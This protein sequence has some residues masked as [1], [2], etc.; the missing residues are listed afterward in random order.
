MK[1]AAVFGLS[2]MV[3]A[4]EAQVLALERDFMGRAVRAL[5]QAA[6]DAGAGL[7]PEALIVEQKQAELS[8]VLRVNHPAA[9][10]REL[11]NSLQPARP[12]L[13]PAVEGALEY[14]WR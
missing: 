11:G 7:P 12:F 1:D 9:V 3:R 10:W 6:I 4:L 2:G 5:E 14:F 13:L 8:V